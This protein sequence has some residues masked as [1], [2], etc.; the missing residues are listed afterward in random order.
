MKIYITVTCPAHCRSSSIHSL[1]IHII[2][3]MINYC[4]IQTPCHDSCCIYFLHSTKH[5]NLFM[6]TSPFRFIA[7]Y[8]FTIFFFYSNK[9]V[10]ILSSIFILILNCVLWW[11]ILITAKVKFNQ[12]WELFDKFKTTWM[13]FVYSIKTIDSA[14]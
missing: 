14:F 13:V 1:P 9:E 3:I 7:Q 5:Q 10:N 6:P 8:F 2:N 4:L 11:S 12:L